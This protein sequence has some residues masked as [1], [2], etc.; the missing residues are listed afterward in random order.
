MPTDTTLPRPEG[1]IY[2]SYSPVSPPNWGIAPFETHVLV[3]SNIRAALQVLLEVASMIRSQRLN[4]VRRNFLA[5]S[6]FSE[7]TPRL[8]NDYFQP[9]CG[10]H[11]VSRYHVNVSV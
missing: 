9:V 2:F 5:G 8:R 6:F 1:H 3:Y 4:V 10:V 7:V 11:G